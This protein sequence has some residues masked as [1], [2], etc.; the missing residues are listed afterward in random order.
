MAVAL[1]GRSILK[2]LHE[3]GGTTTF[4]RLTSLLNADP[5]AVERLLQSLLAAKLVYR[6][7]DE[8]SLSAT[9]RSWCAAE[10]KPDGPRTEAAALTPAFSADK[11][12]EGNQLPA[13]SMPKSRPT[14]PPRKS[15][16]MLGV[17]VVRVARRIEHHACAAPVSV[18]GKASPIEPREPEP[19]PPVVAVGE[20]AAPT[21]PSEDQRRTKSASKRIVVD[22]SGFV[23][24][25]NGRKIY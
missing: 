13:I 8:L 17:Q 16:R 22:K 3:H 14:P 4:T 18:V 6:T 7:S 25:I 15:D 11:P 21:T 12:G 9:G 23:T 2:S 5:T 24:H 1:T 20:I 10:F 19:T